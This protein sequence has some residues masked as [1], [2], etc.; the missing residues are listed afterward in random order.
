MKKRKMSESGP[1]DLSSY[2]QTINDLDDDGVYQICG[3]LDHNAGK[4]A[5]E[6]NSAEQISVQVD[7]T[8]EVY[9]GDKME[10]FKSIFEITQIDENQTGL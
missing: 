4:R 7:D 1:Y 10:V 5:R 8:N 2:D 9:N 3:Q 6:T